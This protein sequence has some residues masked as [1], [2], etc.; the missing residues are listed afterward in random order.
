M[1]GRNEARKQ[2]RTNLQS[3][4]QSTFDGS[5]VPPNC[6][7]QQH[8]AEILSG[9]GFLPTLTRPDGFMKD[10]NA[11]LQEYLSNQIRG[12]S[13]GGTRN[14]NTP[15]TIA[16]TTVANI[17][18]LRQT[19]TTFPSKRGKPANDIQFNAWNV[20]APISNVGSDIVSDNMTSL[21]QKTQRGEM[22]TSKGKMARNWIPSTQ[23]DS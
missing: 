22:L 20:Q 9:G 15:N 14:I 3:E 2:V 11:N 8:E 21:K 18:Q 13:V 16:G 4:G 1:R 6:V 10:E 19:V 23:M 5:I 12:K 7:S 17:G